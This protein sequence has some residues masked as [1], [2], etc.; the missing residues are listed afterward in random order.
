[1]TTGCQPSSAICDEGDAH[2]QQRNADAQHFARGELD[3][4]LAGPFAGQEV[5]GHAQQQR[6]QHHR[7][8]VVV[9]QEGGG[10][11]HHGAGQEAGEERLC[12]DRPTEGGRDRGHARFARPGRGQLVLAELLAQPVLRHLAGGAER[13]RIDEVDVVRRPPAGDLAVEEAFSTSRVTAAPGF[14]TTISNGRSSHF[15]WPRRCRQRSRRRRRH[16]DVLEVAVVGVIADD[17]PV[18]VQLSTD[19]IM[20]PP[21][22]GTLVNVRYLRGMARLDGGLMLVLDAAGALT[23]QEAT[24]LAR[25]DGGEGDGSAE[26][27]DE[28]LVD[29]DVDANPGEP[30]TGGTDLESG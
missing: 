7:R 14:F 10:R 28:P 26:L 12:G 16:G 21:L 23:A 25:I 15:G 29:D 13:D 18:V 4:G 11:G 2:A 17:V 8:V 22:F 5:Q 3:A 30:E 6:E 27:F 19:Q 20:E 1:M 24:W 9:G